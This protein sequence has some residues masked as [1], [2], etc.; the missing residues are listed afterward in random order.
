MPSPVVLATEDFARLFF[1]LI[2]KSGGD[3]GWVAQAELLRRA[4]AAN[5]AHPYVTYILAKPGGRVGF[6]AIAER[7]RRVE[8]AH[9]ARRKTA[10]RRNAPVHF[11]LRAEARALVPA[12]PNDA[13]RTAM[14]GP[15]LALL[16]RAL[17]K[18]Q[19]AEAA[20]G[21][22]AGSA[23]SALERACRAFDWRQ[24]SWPERAALIL[25][26]LFGRLAALWAKRLRTP[27]TAA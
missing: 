5:P 19:A 4:A 6:T 10:F 18:E 15:D 9:I 16:D 3:G 24:P 25:R 23:R 1:R 14:A 7:I 21:T 17:A 11:R 27:S 22:L 2:E 8:F 26:R 12:R 20:A 13:A